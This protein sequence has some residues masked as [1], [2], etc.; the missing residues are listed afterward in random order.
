MIKHEYHEFVIHIYLMQEI[1]DLAYHSELVYLSRKLMSSDKFL[2][3]AILDK[4]HD[5][6]LFNFKIWSDLY[7][8][9]MNYEDDQNDIEER[10]E[11]LREEAKQ[12]KLVS[13]D[14]VEFDELKEIIRE[15][16]LPTNKIM[17][18]IDPVE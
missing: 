3:R 5:Q 1:E 11:E 13:F 17:A 9:V 8:E 15:E 18:M 10:F 16:M 2:R 4:I 6:D 12:L 7:E 14:K